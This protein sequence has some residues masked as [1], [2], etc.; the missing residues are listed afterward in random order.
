MLFPRLKSFCRYRIFIGVYVF[1]LLL[2]ALCSAAR[3]QGRYTISGTVTDSLTGEALIGATIK[4]EQGSIITNSYGFYALTVSGGVYN[5][6]VS[7]IGYKARQLRLNIDQ[8]KRIN[9]EMEAGNA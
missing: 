8:N 7:Y 6:Y 1:A 3:A 4:T 5:L 2:T 9:I